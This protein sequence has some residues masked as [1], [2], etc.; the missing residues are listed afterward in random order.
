M[1]I[2]GF[3]A[4]V[5]LKAHPASVGEDARVGLA[6]PLWGLGAA[7]ACMGIWQTTGSG[8]FAALARVARL[9]LSLDESQHR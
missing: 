3:G 2:P 8:L 9:I 1:F 4:F 5:R 6:G 7:L